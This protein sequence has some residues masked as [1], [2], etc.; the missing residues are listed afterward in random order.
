MASLDQSLMNVPVLREMLGMRQFEQDMANKRMQEQLGILGA[1]QRLA[2][3]R[4]LPAQGRLREAQAQK[5]EF[6]VQDTGELRELQRRLP[7]ILTRGN[8]AEI[9]AAQARLA[10]QAYVAGQFKKPEGRVVPAGGAVVGPGGQ[11]L[12]RNPRAPTPDPFERVLDAANIKDPA[13]RQALMEQYLQKKL[14]HPPGTN[15]YASSVTPAV[16]AQGNPVFIQPSARSGVGPRRVEGF[17]PPE[18]ATDSKRKSEAGVIVGEYEAADKI[19]DNMLGLVQ[20][21]NPIGMVGIPGTAAR[22]A[23]TIAGV[24]SPNAPTPALDLGTQKEMLI[25][26]MKAIALRR[27][28]NLSNKDVERYENLLG[29]GAVLNTPG[30]AVR[31]LGNVKEDLRRRRMMLDMG[32]LSRTPAAEAGPSTG[33]FEVGKVYQDAQGRKAK[34]LGNGKW[35]EVR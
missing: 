30:A 10:P 16:D 5:A 19:I 33:R 2:E 9:A 6:D 15:V 17:Y 23:E 27:D 26:K 4:S 14:T 7:E 24:V 22:V 35:E 8:P 20:G 25:D 3:L 13:R 29:M 11:E 31:A 34:F 32:R 12:Y 1:A 18:R 28:S 21:G